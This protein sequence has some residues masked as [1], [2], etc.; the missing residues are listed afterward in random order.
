MYTIYKG[1]LPTGRWK[2]G[3]D[4]AYPNRAITQ[5]MSEVT[6][7]E[8]HED[9][10][11]A[12]DRELQLQREHG[13]RVDSIPYYM[14]KV[15][16]AKASRASIRNGNHNF[17]N[18]SQEKR[19]EIVKKS[20]WYNSEHQSEMGKR[21]KGSIR[22][23]AISLAKSLNTSWTC[24]SCGKSGKGRGNYTRWHNNCETININGI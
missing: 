11:V 21:N 14:T 4:E 15:N 3:C 10:F 5:V 24:T 16:A 12:S 7:L 1:L 6:V 17:Q 8:T 20:P 22:P 23:H 9:I 19:D 13:V 18:M 2:I